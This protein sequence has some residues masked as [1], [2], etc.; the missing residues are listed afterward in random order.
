MYSRTP[1]SITKFIVFFIPHQHITANFSAIT[2]TRMIPGNVYVQVED[3]LK[4][5]KTLVL[6]HVER[7]LQK[8]KIVIP[9]CQPLL[10]AENFSE[11]KACQPNLLS[12]F[13]TSTKK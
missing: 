12:L 5:M 7:I 1:P 2:F 11:I 8:N 6:I 13:P 9:N 3:M 4:P 10:L